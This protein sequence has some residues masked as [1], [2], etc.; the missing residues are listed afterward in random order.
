MPSLHSSELGG[1]SE[2]SL[3]SASPVC[4]RLRTPECQLSL[5]TP[6]ETALR[7]QFHRLG[8]SSTNHPLPAASAQSPFPCCPTA[9]STFPLAYTSH[10]SCCLSDLSVFLLRLSNDPR[11]PCRRI[12]TVVTATS[13]RSLSLVHPFCMVIYRHRYQH[14]GTLEPAPATAPSDVPVIKQRSTVAFKP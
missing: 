3:R 10:Q 1:N 5:D 7:T 2:Q 11:T 14:D 12:H 13:A 6:T 8:M 4:T 9:C